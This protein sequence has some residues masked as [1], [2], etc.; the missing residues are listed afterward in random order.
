[1][2]GAIGAS[3]M[4][5][6]WAAP[7]AWL[8]Q[9]FEGRPGS[10]WTA[11][12][13]MERPGRE[14]GTDT[15]KACREGTSERIDFRHGSHFLAG[16]SAVFLD[17]SSRTAWVGPRRRFPSRPDAEFAIVRTESF[18]GRQVV[19]AEIRDPRGRGRRLWVDTTLPLVLRSE[20]LGRE[21]RGPD[22]QFLDLRPG[23]P[24]PAGSFKIPTG[25]TLRQGPPPPPKGPDGRIPPERRR[26]AVATP[27]ELAA[28]VGFAPPA[29]PWLPSGFVARNWAWVESRH[30]KAA[31][32]LYGDGDRSVSIFY[33]P[34]TDEPPPICPSQGCKD[35][36]GRSVYFGKNGKFD[37]IVTGD[38]PPEQMEKIAGI[39]K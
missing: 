21:R 23:V 11:S 15:G 5:S 24:C 4:A 18:L 6:L 17:A 1:M 16:D 38:L 34:G 2:I 30:G 7:P 29:P 27:E 31:Q 35:R 28:V 33:R 3:L 36:K 22:R 9:A 20:P 14:A 12:I 25:W 19:V 37:L 32:I 8:D 26:H 13:A 39:R 10:K